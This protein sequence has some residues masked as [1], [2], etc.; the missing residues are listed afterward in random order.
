MHHSAWETDVDVDVVRSRQIQVN[1]QL[2]HDN[3]HHFVLDLLQKMEE[4]GVL[5]DWKNWVKRTE[6]TSF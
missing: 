6:R 2:H 5:K 3:H 1:H 4:M